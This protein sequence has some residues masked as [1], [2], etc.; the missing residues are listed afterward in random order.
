MLSFKRIFTAT[1]CLLLPALTI[2]QPL[3][4]NRAYQFALKHDAGLHAAYNQLMASKELSP[5]ALADLLPSINATASSHDVRQESES[6]FS[7]GGKNTGQF[8]DEGFSVSLRQPLF[9][10]ASL[11]RYKQAS[12]Q[13]SRA[14]AKYRL[15][16]QELILRLTERYLDALQAEANFALANDDVNAFTRQ[17]DQAKLR[18]EVGL[19]AITDVHNAQ[20]KYDLAVATQIAAQNNLYSKQEAL[21]EIIQTDELRLALLADSFPINSPEPNN[22]A[23]WETLAAQQN[24]AIEMAKHDVAI[25]KK[26]VAIN[27]SGHYPT[28]DIVASHNYNET[29]GGSFG[30]TGFRNETD[31]LGLELNMTLFAGGKTLSLTRQA[32]FKH[33]QSLDILQALQRATLR[34][35]RDAFRGVTTSMRR[36]N[37]L[38]QAI[39]SNK[40]SLNANELGLEVGTRTIVDVLD[41]QS[42]LSRAK[43]QLIAAKKNYIL[44]VLTLKGSTGSLS[45]IDIAKLN[46]FLH[47]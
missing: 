43:L 21:R 22:M 44:N 33:Q 29:G 34:E 19:I 23:D 3:D 17:L 18:F 40:S 24:L 9:N 5:Q 8:R 38:E 27:Q 14:E 47:Q 26:E 7:G 41:A 30:N 20:A 16:E 4:L 39:V 28:I 42:N 25:A 46:Q 10:W 12:K 45:K 1:F 32:A 6:S 37:A 15:A 36:I 13:V 35:T 31:R 11:V 2:A